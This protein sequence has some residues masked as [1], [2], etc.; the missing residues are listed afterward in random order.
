MKR[1]L[2]VDPEMGT[3][4]SFEFSHG[5]CYPATAVP[6]GMNFFTLQNE[7]NDRWFYNPRTDL[8]DA[9]RLA[10]M[11]S[12]W[13][14][15]WCRLLFWGGV[16]TAEMR[17]L[18]FDRKSAEIRPAYLRIPVE[19]GGYTVEVTPTMGCARLRFSLLG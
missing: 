17:R 8:F 16:G 12:P 4:N 1:Y 7:D 19:E 2:L 9:V 6:R 14:G 13:L 10:H 15:D 3:E 5:N 18:P 11:P